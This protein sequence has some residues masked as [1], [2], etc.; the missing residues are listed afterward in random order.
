MRRATLWAACLGLVWSAAASAVPVYYTYG[1]FGAG[2][3]YENGDDATFRFTM[4][5]DVDVQPTYLNADGV[6]VTQADLG[7]HTNPADPFFGRY[8]LD[9][10][11]ARLDGT[12]E[13]LDADLS[14]PNRTT[15]FRQLTGA[16]PSQP[17]YE[18]VVRWE[19]G[20]YYIQL[21]RT[22]I[23][24]APIGHY[25]PFIADIGLGPNM[26]CAG[27][28]GNN[29]R[30]VGVSSTNSIPEPATLGLLVLGAGLAFA[31]K[32]RRASH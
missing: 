13:F 11:H 30:L 3:S 23:I 31:V 18:D 32:R 1:Y 6:L 12:T 26:V 10:F 27:S 22:S 5:Y 25:F 7:L 29:L 19:S 20:D 9:Y 17:E 16:N 4:E 15:S 21:V 24:D 14:Q 2:S 8:Q 28:C